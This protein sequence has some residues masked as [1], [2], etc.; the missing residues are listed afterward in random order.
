MKLTMFSDPGHAWLFVSQAQLCTLGLTLKDFSRYSY[1]DRAGAYV[2]QDVDCAI[3]IAA[4]KRVL[5]CVPLIDYV[6]YPT[7]SAYIR[8]L[9]RCGKILT[10]RSA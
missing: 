5:D 7:E 6:D 8:G 10:A 3:V 2:E 9:S 1:H 4:H